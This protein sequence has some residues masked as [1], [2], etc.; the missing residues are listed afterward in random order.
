LVARSVRLVAGLWQGAKAVLVGSPR[1]VVF[2]FR[3]NNR[4]RGVEFIEKTWLN[5]L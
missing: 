5:N 1:P 4:N 3:Q 2:I